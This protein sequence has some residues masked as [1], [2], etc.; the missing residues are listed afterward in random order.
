MNSNQSPIVIRPYCD[1]DAQSIADLRGQCASADGFDPLSTL[2]S[3][4]TAEEIRK[5]GSDSNQELAVVEDSGKIIGYTAIRSWFEEDGTHVFLHNGYVLPDHR[6]GNTNEFLLSWTEGRIEQLAA[7]SRAANVSFATN[8]T[9]SELA[10]TRLLAQNGYA[11]VFS[12]VEMELTPVKTNI[13]LV[14]PDGFAIRTANEDEIPALWELNNLV[15]SGRPFTSVSTEEGL[16]QFV[17]GAVDLTLWRVV[18][19]NGGLIGFTSARHETDKAELIELSVHPQYRRLG[20][21]TSMLAEMVEVLQQ[22]GTPTIRLHTNGEDVAGAM[23][24]YK[25]FGFT[26]CKQYMR[27]RKPLTRLT[28][29]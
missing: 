2:E 27:Y 7:D 1:D 9:S 13:A 25:K 15:Y 26:V 18:E 3:L 11:E 4:P 12:L 24:L 28:G 20:L 19:N 8:A 6:S 29:N 17:N 10:K 21:A 23:S 16:Q 5:I 14:M 22:R